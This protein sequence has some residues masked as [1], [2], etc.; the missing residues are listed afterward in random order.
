[1]ANKLDFCFQFFGFTTFFKMNF[2][3]MSVV[4]TA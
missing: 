3:Q 4:V 2:N 1:M